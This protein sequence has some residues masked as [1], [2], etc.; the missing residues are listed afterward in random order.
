MKV[1]TFGIR[2]VEGGYVLV[3]GGDTTS[4]Y[5]P[6]GN[7]VVFSNLDKALRHLK[8]LVMDELEDSHDA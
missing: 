4:S 8:A 5:V 7:I 1:K 6:W 2:I 3:L